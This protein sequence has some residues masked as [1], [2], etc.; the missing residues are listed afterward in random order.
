MK[1]AL[2]QTVRRSDDCYEKTEENLRK[3]ICWAKSSNNE[4][5]KH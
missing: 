4:I 5:H 3:R 2:D 1:N